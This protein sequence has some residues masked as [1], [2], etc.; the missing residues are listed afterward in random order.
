MEFI[1][2]LHFPDSKKQQKK[3]AGDKN[4]GCA[5]NDEVAHTQRQQNC[6]VKDYR[7]SDC[8]TLSKHLSDQRL[9]CGTDTNQTVQ[10]P[11][12]SCP[13]GDIEPATTR[14][15]VTSRPSDDMENYFRINAHL[16]DNDTDSSMFRE[17]GNTC[18]YAEKCSSGTVPNSTVGNLAV[19]NGSK[20]T[21]AKDE[22]PISDENYIACSTST[23]GNTS[24]DSEGCSCNI[25]DTVECLSNDEGCDSCRR[26]SHELD[27]VLLDGGRNSPND[28]DVE[29]P[30]RGSRGS[31]RNVQDS[32]GS[33]HNVNDSQ[34]SSRNMNDSRGSHR[35][36][37]NA[38]LDFTGDNLQEQMCD[39]G[40]EDEFPDIVSRYQ[41]VDTS[42]NSD[43]GDEHED[44]IE[45][46][47]SKPFYADFDSTSCGSHSMQSSSS[48]D[49]LCLTAAVGV[50]GATSTTAIHYSHSEDTPEKTS[51][52]AQS[53]TVGCNTDEVCEC[54]DSEL[55]ERPRRL[56]VL[57]EPVLG[58]PVLGGSALGEPVLGGS[59]LGGSILDGSALGRS[60]LG[61]SV[62]GGS[63][64][65]GS[66]LGGSVLNGSALGGF[67]LG[68]SALGESVLGGSVL[69]GASGTCNVSSTRS[70]S[71]SHSESSYLTLS[72]S[73]S[74]HSP[75]CVDC[76]NLFGVA[77]SSSSIYT[78]PGSENPAR[79]GETEQ[80]ELDDT[81]MDHDQAARHVGHMF[82]DQHNLKSRETVNTE[83]RYCQCLKPDGV[84]M[85]GTVHSQQTQAPQQFVR[86]FSADAISSAIT[87]HSLA[88]TAGA[89]LRGEAGRTAT[90]NL[91]VDRQ[92]TCNHDRE[93]M[94][95]VSRQT[96]TSSCDQDENNIQQ[97]EDR[98]SRRRRC[99]HF[100][101][102]VTDPLPMGVYED[103]SAGEQRRSVS[104][105][106][107]AVDQ[108]KQNTL[109]RG[110]ECTSSKENDTELRG[111]VYCN[112]HWPDPDFRHHARSRMRE[113]C[114]DTDVTFS[115]S[116]VAARS[117]V[118]DTR[119]LSLDELDV[120]KL[121][122]FY[123][124]QVMTNGHQRHIKSGCD[125]EI[126]NNL[127]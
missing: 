82:P 108:H 121:Q 118:D 47:I 64:L 116:I 32:R 70:D 25:G 77:T 111:C 98:A 43:S 42:Q 69:G 34:G 13:S 124:D 99:P 41:N 19:V 14:P 17:T 54:G 75:F 28:L 126:E 22:I 103:C 24:I 48:N 29:Q 45:V 59:V 83:R 55:V 35:N 62:L 16:L 60:A 125:E 115:G 31:H 117:G 79:E 123:C 46:D 114:R 2:N 15:S 39:L 97:Q 26:F 21:Y 109:T 58:E 80:Y 4:E 65:G 85:K 127:Q 112:V 9:I 49:E 7:L 40:F 38:W 36:V 74:I 101:D 110:S 107:S 5:Q 68:G 73:S 93:D 51:P 105:Q 119:R 1:N 10:G 52:G 30:S 78:P 120:P 71:T 81:L 8:S 95:N 67:V 86:S 61:G 6:D 57:G 89:V 88:G 56:S 20:S 91:N 102:S 44:F 63:A 33:H 3:M 100:K 53:S 66:A 76:D 106:G 94:F 50:P 27:V 72:S 122:V 12:T 104:A 23:L 92:N 113:R 90:N 87:S 96:S 11:A 84:A 18:S 37:Q